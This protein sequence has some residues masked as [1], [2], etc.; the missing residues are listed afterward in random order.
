MNEREE[1]AERGK[2]E[3][4][5]E[6]RLLR[7]SR[8]VVASIFHSAYISCFNQSSLFASPL[9]LSYAV[10]VLL[11]P[12]S[13][14]KGAEREQEKNREFAITASLSSVPLLLA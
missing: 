11:C 2:G 13:C 5:R 8:R 4:A 9:R 6:R 10:S 14:G 7:S 12:H 3:R 1:V